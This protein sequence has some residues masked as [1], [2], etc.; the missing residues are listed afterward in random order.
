MQLHPDALCPARRRGGGGAAA[1]RLPASFLL[2]R[3]LT[4]RVRRPPRRGPRHE[5]EYNFDL[6]AP[7][8][9]PRPDRGRRFAAVAPERPPAGIL[10]AVVAAAIRGDGLGRIRR[11]TA[12]LT[13]CSTRPRS[14]TTCAGRRRIS[15]GWRWSFLRSGRFE[16]VVLVADHVNDPSVHE[17]RHA[18][19]PDCR[20][21]ST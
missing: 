12:S 15:S 9:I 21:S 16:R 8:G 11:R 6:L 3:A 13:R 2:D 7:L 10:A 19:R 5:A 17:I 4:D 14:P 18:A 20:A 1:D